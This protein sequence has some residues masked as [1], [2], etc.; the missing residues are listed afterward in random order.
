MTRAKTLMDAAA[1]AAAIERL[2][3]AVLAGVG[4]GAALVGIHTRGIPIARRIAARIGAAS[5]EAPPLGELDIGLYR[6]DVARGRERPVLRRTE[7]RFPLDDR[8]VVLV[9]DVL[10]TGR[11]IRAALDA[12]TDLGRPRAIRL[13]VL[14]DRGGRELPIQ[15]DFVGATL[16]VP[17][18]LAVEVRLEEVDGGPDRVLA[19]P[20]ADRRADAARQEDRSP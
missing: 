11:T 15:A 13:G 4:E 18:E 1:V 3:G 10:F 12:L 6:D 16:A 5:G 8:V 2:A 14:V 9:D 19:V 7:I 20:W 17:P